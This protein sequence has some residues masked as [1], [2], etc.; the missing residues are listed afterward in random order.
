MR[1]RVAKPTNFDALFQYLSEE[2]RGECPLLS[3]MVKFSPDW[4][5]KKVWHWFWK[6]DQCKYW[7]VP[8]KFPDEGFT[9]PS[10]F[11]RDL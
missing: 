2:W 11:R 9:L 5:G 1:W 3:E 10:L 8:A 6:I 7:R 4:K